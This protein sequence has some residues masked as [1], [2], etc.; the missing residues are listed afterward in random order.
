MPAGHAHVNSCC[1]SKLKNDHNMSGMGVMGV[2]GNRDSMHKTLTGVLVELCPHSPP[3]PLR[4]KSKRKKR[5]GSSHAK[6]SSIPL[7]PSPQKP[8]C[9]FDDVKM[10]TIKVI[11][12]NTFSNSVTTLNTWIASPERH[13][14]I[15]NPEGKAFLTTCLDMKKPFQS[16]RPYPKL[17]TPPTILKLSI[18]FWVWYDWWTAV[19]KLSNK[20]IAL[21]IEIPP[22]KELRC[23]NE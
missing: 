15:I 22:I 5:K 1:S 13:I 17:C 2:G 6:L 9:S 3:W 11:V 20:D 8:S 23:T 16:V 18:Y 7:F 19:N 4:R 12:H 21:A 10:S 14:Y